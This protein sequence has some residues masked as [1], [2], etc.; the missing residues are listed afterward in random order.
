[1]PRV[2]HKITYKHT[3]DNR[4]SANTNNSPFTSFN[5]SQTKQDKAYITNIIKQYRKNNQKSSVNKY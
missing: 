4:F 2:V 3:T 5:K 1:V